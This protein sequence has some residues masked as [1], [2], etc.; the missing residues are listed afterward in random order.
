[1]TRMAGGG[2]GNIAANLLR[3]TGG[4]SLKQVGVAVFN[5]ACASA[6]GPYQFGMWQALKL[7][8]TYG[9]NLTGGTPYALER[10]VP[11]YASRDDM[12]TARRAVAAVRRQVLAVGAVVAV[13][14]IGLALVPR[15]PREA[16]LVLAGLAF[17][18]SA[19]LLS[20]MYRV[21][22]KGE[23]RFAVMGRATSAFGIIVGL[24][25]LLVIRW[26]L[27]GLL[28]GQLLAVLASLAVY[29]HGL[30]GD[31]AIAP[32]EPM[33]LRPIL[34][35]GMPIMFSSLISIYQVTVDRLVI[36]SMLGAAAVGHYALG[37]LLFV[38][39]E[40]LVGAINDVFYPRFV[41]MYGR[42][43]A[44]ENR[45]R[46]LSVVVRSSAVLIA[47]AVG[48]LAMAAPLIV[49]LV[50]P[51]YVDGIRSAQ[52]LLVAL[53]CS[54]MAALVANVFYTLSRVRL[55][56]AWQV[57][58]GLS[59]LAAAIVVS[60]WFGITGVAFVT[61]GAHACYLMALMNHAA[62]LHEQPRMR[63]I[64]A[65]LPPLAPLALVVTFVAV[66]WNAGYASDVPPRT[67]A[68]WLLAFVGLAVPAA[69]FEA[70][71]LWREHATLGEPSNA[72]SHA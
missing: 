54:S 16:R 11:L 27:V 12:D 32:A 34:A 53:A 9:V 67:S 42:G 19:T 38:P 46:H 47:V 5:F 24:A 59:N 39:L 33:S 40:R 52:I 70:Y 10:L 56:V 69:V 35:V 72:M 62:R 71:R 55:L 63:G 68:A 3:L 64:A 49:P 66:S 36:A 6:I 48:M 17:I 31:A 1:M 15:F 41:A 4:S 7:V 30:S 2:L 23:R 21:I 29:R 28:A 45:F 37:A 51:R 44:P 61:L 57:A 60:R 8:I 22:C 18:L 13:V 26:G 65:A 58:A 25:S 43:E 14:L 20:D 50:L